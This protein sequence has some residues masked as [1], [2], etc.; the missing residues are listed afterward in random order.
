MDANTKKIHGEVSNF[1]EM[2][3]KVKLEDDLENINHML[4]ETLHRAEFVLSMLVAD[5]TAEFYGRLELAPD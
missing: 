4:R 5:D 3:K 1:E 2:R